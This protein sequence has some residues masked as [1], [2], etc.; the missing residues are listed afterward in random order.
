[1]FPAQLR[2]RTSCS[3]P[4]AELF[5]RAL[6]PSAGDSPLVLPLELQKQVRRTAQE[7]ALNSLPLTDG[8]L[9]T[10]WVFG[11]GSKEGPRLLEPL[12]AH[13]F[14]QG[15]VVATQSFALQP[16]V[17]QVER[18]D[19]AAG[20]H[21]SSGATLLYGESFR[22]R[23]R[24]SNAY[25]GHTGPDGPLLWA[26]P[27]DGTDPPSGSRFALHGG[28]LGTPIS[29]GRKVLFARVTSPVPSPSWPDSEDEDSDSERS[30]STMRCD[31]EIQ[32]V[33]Q[34]FP[35]KSTEPGSQ[36]SAPS[37]FLSSLADCCNFEAAFLPALGAP[38][39]FA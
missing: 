10:V 24:K 4:E 39:P 13:R 12:V 25:V 31:F 37:E 9:V 11:P 28:E 26:V 36:P 7:C 30:R 14:A 35:T 15:G 5:K 1:M 34:G 23:C 21:A 17:L 2:L 38:A 29:L 18:Y 3:S 33:A 20:P 6:G 19:S 16:T 22:L 8:C 32:R 27:T